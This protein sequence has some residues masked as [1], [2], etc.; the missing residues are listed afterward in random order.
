MASKDQFFVSNGTGGA[1]PRSNS[2]ALELWLARLSSKEDKEPIEWIKEMIKKAPNERITAAGLMERIH[3]YE[4]GY[5]YYNS[6]CNGEVE[7][8]N[9][10]SY[11][12]SISEEDISAIEDSQNST[13]AWIDDG[14]ANTR[15][16]PSSQALGEVPIQPQEIPP[17][18]LNGK[19]IKEPRTVIHHS[20]A[21]LEL[22]P[23]DAQAPQL[24]SLEQLQIFKDNWNYARFNNFSVPGV[25]NYDQAHQ[26]AVYTIQLSGDFLVTA[27]RDTTIRI[28][29][30]KTGALVRG[31][32]KGHTASVFCLKFDE[33]EKEDVII[34]AGSDASFITWEF[35]TGVLRRKVNR[36]HGSSILHLCFDENYLVTGS[37]DKL[38]K[39]WNRKGQT[40]GRATNTPN[41]S[42]YLPSYSVIMTL[43]GH[44]AAVNTIQ[45]DKSEII[46]G[47]GDRTIKI[48]SLETG[49]CLRTIEGHILGI[50]CLQLDSGYIISGSSDSTVRI[51]D[52][53][54][55]KEE[56]CLV[57]HSNLVRSLQVSFADNRI[58]SGSY[59][60]TIIVWQQNASGN[61]I[62]RHRLHEF[63]SFVTAAIKSAGQ[64]SISPDPLR[65]DS[66]INWIFGVQ[67]DSR[68]LIC[69]GMRR[70]VGWDFSS[71]NSTEV[72]VSNSH[73]ESKDIWQALLE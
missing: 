45:L 19:N 17:R 56:F 40:L 71:G 43:V 63:N 5:V 60:G 47:S 2:K 24:Y 29:N 49:E 9:G 10:T 39:V 44:T 31:P 38:I 1:N 20:D 69:C 64:R 35:S 67:F 25:E 58:V 68:F 65:K 50:A 36:A 37:K 57:G 72:E 41:K 33:S 34:S 73:S 70:I 18:P 55:G 13:K 12:G 46:S 3:N 26:E 42:G 51:F 53:A 32:L 8:E 6:C 48:W 23:V 21:A 14:A 28:W 4:D 66:T 27:G 7:S 16:P 11:Q 62:V 22:G 52:R 15:V 61:W 59:D 54:T 30:I